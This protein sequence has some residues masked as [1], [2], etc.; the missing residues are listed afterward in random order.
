MRVHEMRLEAGRNFDSLF[1]GITVTFADG[2]RVT[3]IARGTDPDGRQQYA[4]RVT[5]RG[6]PR[7][8]AA[9]H[10]LRSG[11]GEPVNYRKALAAWVSF[12]CADADTYRATMAGDLFEEW[13]YLRDDELST[14]A[15]DLDDDGDPTGGG[16]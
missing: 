7:I 3:L 15:A 2:S 5:Q 14:L 1:G 4:Y 11:I 8:V 16:A 6:E 13:A 12:A 9:G 10:N